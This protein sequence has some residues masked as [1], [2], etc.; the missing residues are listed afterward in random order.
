MKTGPSGPELP[1]ET[2]GED[3][4]YRRAARFLILIGGDQAA[5][6]ISQLDPG[7]VERI[8]REIASI[9]GITA[10]EAEAVLGEFRSLL[11]GSRAYSGSSSGGVEAAR[12]LLYAAFGPDKGESLLTRAVPEARE[13]PFAFL[14]GFSGEQGVL[15]LREESAM[16]AALI[17]SQVS[18]KFSAAVLAHMKGERKLEI[19]RRIARLESVSPEVLERV[20]AGLREKA[21]H[22][23]AAGGSGGAGIDGMN[24]LTAILKHSDASFGDRILGELEEDDPDLS[25]D[26]KERLHTL[27]DVI[28]AEDRP[29]QEKLRA[30]SDRD[31][32]LLLKGRSR[33]F[34]E[35]I[36]SNVSSQ[37]RS[38]IR[39][40]EGL[41]GPVSRRETEAAAREFLAWF[42][43]SREEGRILLIDS[44]DVVL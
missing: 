4:K 9:R 44:E 22:I 42:R 30:M 25:R 7:Q 18:P 3:G 16:T 40:E 8:S 41:M 11:A 39:E 13:N 21:R 28:R 19:L 1:P 15:L 5:R 32:A 20:A 33:P 12:R 6:I 17:L 23:A 14:E 36:L 31:I 29:L 10:E 37:R 24:A 26:I 43:L 27:D 34:A 38:R 2:S 35:K